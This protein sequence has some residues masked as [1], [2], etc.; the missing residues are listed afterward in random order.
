MDAQLQI[1]IKCLEFHDLPIE[2]GLIDENEV[3]PGYG[4][5]SRTG[6]RARHRGD[7]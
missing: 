3:A 2:D 5:E 7:V 6:R 4:Y 1:C